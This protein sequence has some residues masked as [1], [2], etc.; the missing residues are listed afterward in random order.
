MPK[1]TLRNDGRW[2][3][4]LPRESGKSRRYVYARTEPEVQTKYQRAIGAGS[5][6]VRPGSV[7]EFVVTDY[8]PHQSSAVQSETFARYDHAWRTCVGPAIGSKLFSELGPDDLVKA[9]KG[10]GHGGST[11]SSAKTVLLSILKLAVLR[12]RCPVE[13]VAIA[14]LITIDRPQPK[15]R[16]DAAEAAAKMLD[17]AVRLSHWTEGFIYAA[18]TV[19]FRKGELC[20]IKRTDIDVRARTITLSRQRNHVSGE[21]GRLK[22]RKA[23]DVRRIGLPEDILQKL[24]GYF[25]D[26]AIYLITDDKG[27]PPPTNHFERHLA[28]I[29]EA[30]G[31]NVT[32]HDL[33]AAA[34]CRLIDA[35][36]TDHE[37]QEIVGH[38][39]R[40]M[41]AWYRD[42]SASRSRSGLSRLASSDNQ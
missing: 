10:S 18:S 2:T 39:D 35:G 26:G 30:A 29:C 38:A 16:E 27:K 25:K 17:A 14:S 9:L 34:I 6:R 8:V 33:R 15:F 40:D 32:P 1:A 31:V 24:L 37:I 22:S 28:P 19:G 36:A 41:I 11:Q 12:K 13:L 3:I 42:R 21:K 20:A 23:G 5:V 4:A 7:A